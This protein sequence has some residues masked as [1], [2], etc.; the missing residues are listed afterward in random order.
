MQTQIRSA[1]D[2]SD[3]RHSSQPTT[4]ITDYNQNVG[5]EDRFDQLGSYYEFPHPAYEWH[6]LFYHFCTEAALVIGFIFQKRVNY[7]YSHDCS[8]LKPWIDS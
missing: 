2:P 8:A 3:L 4:T 1:K 6:Q 5:G 7:K